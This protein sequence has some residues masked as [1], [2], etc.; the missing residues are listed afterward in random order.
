MMPRTSALPYFVETDLLKRKKVERRHPRHFWADFVLLL[1]D[2]QKE[3]WVSDFQKH[4][5]SFE[6]NVANLLKISRDA[7][8]QVVHIRQTFSKDKT[9]WMPRYRLR[10]KAPCIRFSIGAQAVPFAEEREGE[11]IFEK[12]TLDAFCNPQLE[13][14]L[15]TNRKKYVLTCGLTTSMCVLLTA[16]SSFQRGYL[17]ALIE[18][19]CADYPEAHSIVLDRFRG[20]FDIVSH[21]QLTE[22]HSRWN[23]QI[24]QLEN[25]KIRG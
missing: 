24:S 2:V 23:S 25:H 15:R 14:F 11:V 5:P 3:F 4:F 21:H 1:I 19:C 17:T 13:E 8:I 12:Q 22:S 16:S 20:F 9:D 7:G 10:D 18:D 6:N